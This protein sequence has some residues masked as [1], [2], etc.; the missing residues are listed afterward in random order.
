MTPP[1]PPPAAD[2]SFADTGLPA[3]DVPTLPPA[4]ADLWRGLGDSGLV[5][6]DVVL[7]KLS[8]TIWPDAAT[9]QRASAL[10]ADWIRQVR[11]ADAVSPLDA[12]L[13]EY[14][15]SS[16][17]GWPS[18]AWPRPCCAFPTTPPPSG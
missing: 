14:Q 6:D 7:E 11:A 1:P 4:L 2:A 5:A 13:H 10:A 16:A 17:E 15:L 3:A 12:F 8:P 18:C 9:A